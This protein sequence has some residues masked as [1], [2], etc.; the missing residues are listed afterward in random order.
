M[1]TATARSAL[2]VERRRGTSQQRRADLVVVNARFPKQLV[3][4]ARERAAARGI[5]MAQVLSD[6]ARHYLDATARGENE[7]ARDALI[8]RR[9]THLELKMRT[10]AS[11]E[12]VT[13]ETLDVLLQLLLGVLP[14]QT[15]EKEQKAY[16]A[17][18]THRID[19]AYAAIARGLSR[20][21]GGLMHRLPA[22]AIAK[23]EDFPE[24][25]RSLNDQKAPAP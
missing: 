4:A 11:Q 16:D 21:A 20:S 2:R 8:A 3:D 22:D 1:A 12:R 18:V 7:D 14:E 6:A 23:S 5:S 10:L 9:L 15:T 19:K 24:P 13:L 25:P 17:K